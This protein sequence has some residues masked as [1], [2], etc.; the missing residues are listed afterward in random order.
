[1]ARLLDLEV[2]MLDKRTRKGAL[3]RDGEPCL[4]RRGQRRKRAGKRP[5]LKGTVPWL[6]DLDVCG[7][8]Y[9]AKVDPVY[10][11]RKLE[12]ACTW[13]D[14]LLE[15]L[16]QAE[17][18]M[19][20]ALIHELTHAINEASGLRSAIAAMF[21]KMKQAELKKL[22]EIMCRMQAPAWLRLWRSLGFRLPRKP[23]HRSKK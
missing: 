18:R 20:D 2:T 1:M 19:L 9:V 4:H 11:H 7:Q 21:P 3:L 22:D 23:R 10:D 15:V 13:S 17:D 8:R 5:E 16:E 6:K 12:G 14:N